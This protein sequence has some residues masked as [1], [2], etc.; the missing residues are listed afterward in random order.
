MIQALIV[1]DEFRAA[2]RLQKM[3]EAAPQQIKVVAKLDSIESTVEYLL[4]NPAPQLILLDIQ[5]ADGLSFEIFQHVQPQSYIIFTTAYDEYALQAFQHRSIAY[6]LKPIEAT[7]LYD[8]LRKYTEM[9]SLPPAETY[10]Q[11]HQQYETEKQVHR[12]RFLIQLGTRIIPLEISEISYIVSEQKNTFAIHSGGQRY[13]LDYS[14]DQLERILAPEQFFRINRQII[15]A[16]HAI[17]AI[18][19]YSKSRLRLTIHP[20]YSNEILVSNTRVAAFKQWLES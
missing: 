18:N 5:L 10:Q 19:A 13:A 1:E 4:Q 12:R 14:L 8:A 16:H 17:S 3:L 20:P 7:K 2:D 11:L 15:V 9:I 6:L